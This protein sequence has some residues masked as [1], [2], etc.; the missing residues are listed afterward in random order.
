VRHRWLV[1][2]FLLTVACLAARDAANATRVRR[3]DRHHLPGFDPYVYVAMAEDPAFFTVAPWGYRILSPHLVHLLWPADEVR[4]FRWL[5]LLGL[6]LTGPLLFLW[7]RRLGS[8]EPW[9]LLATGLFFFSPPVDEVFR[10]FFLA[11]P[12]ALPLLLLA[13]L[14]LESE[15]GSVRP[16]CVFAAALALGALAKDVVIVL[17]PGLLAASTLGQGVRAGLA[18]TAPGAL[19][20]LAVHWGLRHVWAPYPPL[21]APPSLQQMASAG[22]RV[23]A[24][25]GDWWA[26]LFA[27]GLPLALVGLLVPRG[28]PLA[29]RY[30][31]LLLLTLALPFAAAVY[32][33]G[34]TPAEHFYTD[35]V[36]RLLAYALPVLFALALS[37]LARPPASPAPPEPIEEGLPRPARSVFAGGSALLAVA[38]MA[39]P[40]TIL[41]PYRRADLRGR[42]DG[43]FVLAFCRDSLAMARRL[44]ADRPVIYEPV[45]RRFRSG[46]SDPRHMERMRWFLREGWGERPE[47]GMEEVAMQAPSAAVVLPVL[48]PRDLVLALEL[49]AP[50]RVAVGV[51]VNGRRL[52]EVSAEPT[53]VRQRL[54]VPGTALIRGDNRLTLE[55]AEPSALPVTLWVLNLRAAAPP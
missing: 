32:T 48:E 54:I 44:A 25:A 3:F 33:G 34:P 35:D 30:A 43:P 4:G 42:T 39:L 50:R 38:A 27:C 53:A 51:L 16:A 2:A 19:V 17:L 23:L 47:Y 28:R 21:G 1:A 52:G 20:A 13:L 55:V 7:L 8:S 12:V 40:L 45:G 9:S 36:P 46:R 49:R 41:D 26:P 11:E 18:R 24:A 10:N 14:A 37:A 6:G 29:R 5:S 31:L 15:D 22:A